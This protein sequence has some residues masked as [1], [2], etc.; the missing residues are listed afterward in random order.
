MIV[1]EPI[2]WVRGERHEPVAEDEARPA[3]VATWRLAARPALPRPPRDL[4]ITK[5]FPAARPGPSRACA[6]SERS[7]A[8]PWD[9]PAVMRADPP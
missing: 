8:D 1:V 3:P 9:E 2:G 5:Q 7:R 6:A 4:K